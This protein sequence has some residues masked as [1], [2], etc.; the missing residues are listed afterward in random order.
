ME[1]NYILAMSQIWLH[2]MILFE[3]FKEN[4]ILY[5]LA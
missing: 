4:V 2:A 1:E 3:H 5:L